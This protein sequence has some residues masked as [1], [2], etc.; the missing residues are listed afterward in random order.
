MALDRFQKL[1]LGGLAAIGIAFATFSGSQMGKV[2]SA[3]SS[4][5]I[6]VHVTGAVRNQGVVRIAEGSNV[7]DALKAAGGTTRG[8]DLSGLNLAERVVDGTKIEIAGADT[9][10]GFMPG[11]SSVVSPEPKRVV[12]SASVERD[13]A[14][15]GTISLSR[16]SAA[17][18][19]KLP[20]VGP[21]TAAKIIA[22]REQFGPFQSVEDLQKVKGIGPK[23]MAEIRP[24][25]SP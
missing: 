4:G 14:P 13:D 2:S 5:Q 16:A 20:G 15:Q 25:V 18:L 6:Q 12:A 22:Y 10:Q 17:E 11:M 8:A 24:L 1:G 7:E 3:T 23:K 19:D 21:A 9:I